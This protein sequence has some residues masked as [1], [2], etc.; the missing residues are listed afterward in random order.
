MR[1]KNCLCVSSS[2][3]QDEKLVA[4]H[5]HKDGLRHKPLKPDGC[6]HSALSRRAQQWM[7]WFLR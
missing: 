5:P 1:S 3:V 2:L 4:Q 6:L 7:T